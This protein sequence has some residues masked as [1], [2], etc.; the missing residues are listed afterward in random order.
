[1]PHIHRSSHS[2]VTITYTFTRTEVL[3]ALHYAGLIPTLG[4][5]G[6]VPVRISEE[7]YVRVPGGGDWSNTQ[8]AIEDDCP[9]IVKVTEEEHSS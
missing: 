7:V 2:T 1:M 4:A 9:L 3:N 8:L 5:S 6:N